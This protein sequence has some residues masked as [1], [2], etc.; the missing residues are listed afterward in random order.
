MNHIECN[1]TEFL[2]AVDGLR[3]TPEYLRRTC[4]PLEDAILQK[5]SRLTAPR[6]LSFLTGQ[7]SLLKCKNQ[8]SICRFLQGIRR[9]YLG[10]MT[11]RG[12]FW[13]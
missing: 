5:N 12:L 1:A 10:I 13:T 2:S 9:H 3:D 6:P 11:A 7:G 4:G 8:V